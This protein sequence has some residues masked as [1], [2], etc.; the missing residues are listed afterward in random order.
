EPGQV[1]ADQSAFDGAGHLIEAAMG[2]VARDLLARGVERFVVAG[3]ETSGA[4]AAGLG[5][6][7]LSVGAEIAP[8][9]P[10]VT[11][12]EPRARLVF[13]SGNFGAPAFFLDAL[14]ALD[15]TIDAVAEPAS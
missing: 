14:R 10:L 12:A 1:A 6:R 8:G 3:G 9:G 7:M 2:Q 5:V 11:S 4:V 15:V 13:K